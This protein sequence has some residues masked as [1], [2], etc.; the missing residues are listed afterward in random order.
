MSGKPQVMPV[1]GF[2]KNRKSQDEK[3]DTQSRRREQRIGEP[4]FG[5]VSAML[6]NNGWTGEHH[7]Q[8]VRRAATVLGDATTRGAPIVP[9]MRR[10]TMVSL[11]TATMVG[12]ATA[13]MV[14]LAGRLLRWTAC[15]RWVL[16]SFGVK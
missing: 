16:F 2:W 7:F 9:I 15:R 4:R 14:S 11:A 3:C 12:L 1:I 6:V 13:T 5:S 8:G 10:V